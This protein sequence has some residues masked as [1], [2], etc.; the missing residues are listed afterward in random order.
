MFDERRVQALEAAEAAWAAASA[1]IT[2]AAAPIGNRLV[3]SLS[4]R[5]GAALKPMR[6]I[7]TTYRMV[8]RP[9]PTRPSPYVIAVLQPLR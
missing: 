1:G 2:A 6:G 4:E 5:C 3:E 7:A 8:N 9:M